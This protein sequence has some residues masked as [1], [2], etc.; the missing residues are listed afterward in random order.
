MTLKPS[1]AN[2]LGTSNPVSED[3]PMTPVEG[4]KEG[5]KTQA[6]MTAAQVEQKE[7]TEQ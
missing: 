3:S 2:A 4:Q 6:E 7:A 5:G 1:M